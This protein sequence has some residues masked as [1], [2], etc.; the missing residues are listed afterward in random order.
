MNPNDFGNLI[1]EDCQK[2]D[3]KDLL[4]EVKAKLK[5]HLL[6]L[7]LEVFGTAINI[8]TSNT[9]NGGLRYWFKCPMSGDRCAVLYR[10]PVTGEWASRKALNLKYRKSAKKGMM[11]LMFD[12]CL[13]GLYN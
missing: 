9:G 1:V 8:I 2:I 11:E 12:K 6:M 4:C 5:K 10:H 13:I 7:E 3:M